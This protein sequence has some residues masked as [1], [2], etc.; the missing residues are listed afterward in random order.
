M[1]TQRFERK[2]RAATAQS[3]AVF[4]KICAVAIALS[5]G[6]VAPAWSAG[7][8]LDAIGFTTLPGDQV[9]VRLQ[10]SSPLTQDPVAFT[11]DK[12]ARIALDLPATQLNLPQRHRAIGVGP[13]QSVSAVSAGGRT[14][15][16]LN[17]THLVPYTIKR[18]G[19][20]VAIETGVH[21]DGVAAHIERYRALRRTGWRVADCFS[22]RWR[23]DV[24]GCANEIARALKE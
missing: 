10:L 16:V 6:L 11:I 1:K 9:Q 5:L 21:P 20:A 4:T 22:S 17:L 23:D 7:P 8:T 2:G 13:A 12:P 15:V 3:R 18:D 19:N 24:A 14:R